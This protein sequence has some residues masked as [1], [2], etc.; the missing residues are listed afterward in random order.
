MHGNTA[1]ALDK[2]KLKAECVAKK[3]Q[4]QME[5][6]LSVQNDSLECI[7]ITDQKR[8]DDRMRQHTEKKRHTTTQQQQTNS[9]SN[10]VLSSECLFV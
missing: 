4:R 10:F 7:I 2:M 6:D 1:T 5:H 9:N 3:Q 8:L